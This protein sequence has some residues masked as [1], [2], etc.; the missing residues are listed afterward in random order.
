MDRLL[1]TDVYEKNMETYFQAYPKAALK[2]KERKYKSEGLRVDP[3][4]CLDQSI[5]FSVARP[6]EKTFMLSGVFEPHKALEKQ[7]KKQGKIIPNTPIIIIGMGNM[8]HV[9][10]YLEAAREDCLILVYE[11]S[12]EVFEKVMET[13]DIREM[14]LDKPVMLIVEQLNTEDLKTG[15]QAMMK[16][17][18]IA[19]M[20]VHITPNYDILFPKLVK[21]TLQYLSKIYDDMI[22]TWN[23]ARRYTDVAG[24]NVIY[25]I[26]HMLHGYNVSQLKNLLE[27]QIP[28]FV[29]SAGPSLNKNIDQLKKVGDKGCIIAVDTAIKPLLNRGILPDFFVIVDGKKPTELMDHPLISKIPLV[30]CTIVAKGIMDL[31]QGKKFFYT[32]DNPLELLL[33][34]EARKHAGE[35]AKLYPTTLAT[36]GSVANSAFSLAHFMNAKNIIFVGQDLALT[37]NRTHADGTF[38]EKMS[39]ISEREQ[40]DTFP[41]EGIHGNVVYTRT[42]FYR[43]LKW[44]EENIESNNMK[45]V[46]DAT[47]G[48]AKIHGTK[49]MSLERAI[50]T[51]CVEESDW[52]EQFLDLPEMMDY[53]AKKGFAKWYQ[54]LE[55]NFEQVYLQA[56]RGQSIYERMEKIT[57]QKTF[58][59]TAYR[60]LVKK[61]GKINQFMNENEYALFVQDNLM[62]LNFVMRVSIYEGLEDESDDRLEIAKQGKV[63]NFYI[64]H[65]AK[66]WMEISRD[67]VQNRPLVF[68]IEDVQGPLDQ[69]TM[70]YNEVRDKNGSRTVADKRTNRRNGKSLGKK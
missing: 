10:M 64:K 38:Q 25:N 43:Y 61:A 27:G 56:K 50:R 65:E 51:L 41:V 55:D 28:A 16:L 45:N 42:D 24:E 70:L 12:V 30:T 69:L 47:Q 26:R 54:E 37:N 31:H 17:D 32:S 7:I 11:P 34:K 23:T 48:G 49:I 1:H 59:A 15:L 39:K 19:S 20:K 33:F 5:S 14:I 36:G 63:M 53:S 8:E 13:I 68:G 3:I 6:G 62:H 29:V 18:T 67:L 58:N 4:Q 52:K 9:K 2:F 35:V 40:K 21:E 60:D 44:F 22:V 57:G 46:I 66:R